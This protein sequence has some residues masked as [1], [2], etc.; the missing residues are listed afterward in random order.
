M[1][2]FYAI[3]YIVGLFLMV[4]GLAN[5]NEC[6]SIMGFFLCMDAEIPV[7]GDKIIDAINQ[8]KKEIK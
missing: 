8:R 6:M 1:R 3:W 2:V 4:A 7:I 5:S